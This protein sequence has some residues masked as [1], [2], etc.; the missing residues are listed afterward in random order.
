M[1]RLCPRRCPR[2]ESNPLRAALGAAAQPSGSRGKKGERRRLPLTRIVPELCAS[3]DAVVVA[4]PA[5]GQAAA[6]SV[7]RSRSCRS[8]TRSWAARYSSAVSDRPS[9][10]SVRSTNRWLTNPAVQRVERGGANGI[11]ARI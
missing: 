5:P 2:R 9:S 11:A 6:G 7:I 3:G 1:T 8:V 10:S 4:A